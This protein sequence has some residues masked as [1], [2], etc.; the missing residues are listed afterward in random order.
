MGVQ[1]EGET[2]AK[3]RPYGS[4]SVTQR[5]DGKWVA[6]VEAGWTD[7]GTR[8]RISRVRATEAEAK[9]ALRDLQRELAEGTAV[10]GGKVTVK[11]W[12]DEWLETQ[13]RRGRAEAQHTEPSTVGPWHLPH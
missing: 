5:P 12:A 4:G 11:A 9:R 2:V 3:R 10:G 6:R 8:R 7:R 13:A 1:L